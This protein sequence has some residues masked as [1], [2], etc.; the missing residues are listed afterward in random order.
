M[1]QPQNLAGS[2]RSVTA[3]TRFANLKGDYATSDFVMRRGGRLKKITVAYEFWGELSVNHDNVILIFT[4]LSP[5]AHAASSALDETPGWW[6]YM[7]GPGKSIDTSRF[8][9]ICVNSLGSCFGSTG[10][11]SV[12]PT[13]GKIY[14]T[15]FPDL[16][17]E[18]IAKAGHHLLHE[19]GIDH[20][21]AVIGPSMGGMVALAYALQ[22]PDEVDY[23]VSISAATWALPFTIAMRSLQR[24]I[25]RADPVWNGGHYHD[26][27]EPLS[28]MAL[29]R[30]LGLV[31]YRAAEEWH[32][33]FD[34]SRISKDRRSGKP[35]EIEFEV[36]SYLDYNA[37]KFINNF[38]AN[39]YLYLSRTM[40]WF[41][42]A[43]HGGSVMAGLAMIRV[44]KALIIGV[45]TDILFPLEQQKEI[46]QGLQKAGTDVDFVE[47]DSIN[48]HDAF[49]V[50]SEHFS[51]VLDKFLTESCRSQC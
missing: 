14:A 49:L 1:T 45:T 48:G 46:V 15:D 20:L 11:E 39:C 24:E 12:D 9:V 25:I 30:K 27:E 44:K 50:D 7:I 16:T 36:E 19:I 31:S 47:I 6:E 33:R 10:P 13:S 4:G 28:G 8:H 21:H 5:S 42:V 43:E 22:Y 35:F 37:Q 38:D 26:T 23:L 18:D 40:D 3:A 51:P 34:R 2:H 32:Q 29:A 17:I 41:D